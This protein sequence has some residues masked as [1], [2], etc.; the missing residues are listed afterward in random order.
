MKDRMFS[1]QLKQKLLSTDNARHKNVPL[2]LDLTR[3]LKSYHKRKEVGEQASKQVDPSFLPSD[4]YFSAFWVVISAKCVV[5]FFLGK[6]LLYSY[7]LLLIFTEVWLYNFY[8]SRYDF[9]TACFFFIS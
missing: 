5:L 2:F 9:Q 6:F 1:F 7:K 3:I 8:V 4:R